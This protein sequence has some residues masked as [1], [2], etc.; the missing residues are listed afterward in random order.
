M[1]EFFGK[2]PHTGVNPGR[3][4]RH[5]RGDP[6]R[7]AAGRRQGR[8]AAR[9]DA[10]VARHRDLGRRVHADDRP[11]HDHPDQEEPGLLDR[12][13]QSECGHDPGLPGRARNGRATTRC[14]A[15]STW[16]AFRRR[17]AACRR[18]RSRSTSTPTASSTSS[19]KDKGTGKEQ[20]IRIQASGGLADADIDKMVKEAE[21]FAEEDKK[22]RAEAEAKNNAESLIHS[23]EKQLAEHGDKVSAEVKTEIETALAEAKTAVEGGDPDAD[24]REDQC[25]DPGG[26]EARPG[27]VRAAAGARRRAGGRGRRGRRSRRRG[28]AAPRK[29]WS[30]PNS[31]KSTT[32]TR[33]NREVIRSSRACRR[34]V[35]LVTGTGQDFGGLGASGVRGSLTWSSRIITSCWGSQRGADDAAIK[36]AYRRLAK[37][38]HPDRHGGCTEQEAQFKAISEAYDVPQ[39]PAEARRL[40]PLRQ[41]RVPEWRRRR[42]VRR[43]RG[44]NGFSDIFSSIFGE[45]MDPRGQRQNAARGA[46]LRYDLELTLEEAFAGVEQDGHDRSAG[47]R[48]SHATA[49]AAPRPNDCAADL[50]RPAAARARSARSRAF[51]SSSAAARHCRGSGE[52]DR[53]PVP[54][55]RRRRPRAQPAQAVGEDS[56]R[57]RRRHAHPRCRRRRG[58]RARRGERRPLHVRPHEAA[59]DLCARRHDPGRRMPGQLHH[60]GAGRLDQPARDRRR[61]GRDQDS[62]RHPV[63]RA[64]APA[65]RRA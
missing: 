7:R 17:R 30:T 31:P 23:T 11:Q 53:R 32:R 35:L 43:R 44:F 49:A 48:A 52:I 56:R 6:G 45:F 12:R 46:D 25:A 3:S 19:A 15:S 51:S 64:A 62:R 26:D 37:E 34:T 55:L 41:G 33:A 42:P 47:A 50:P 63:G 2:E 40:R 28:A 22:R 61:A 60:R 10:A 27:D 4:R 65:R 21:Q 38:C 18:S 54:A 13:R 16:S 58:R 24:D 14:S 9:R 36:A 20:Q 39:G 8:A 29:T 1:K 57:G 59:R 5:G